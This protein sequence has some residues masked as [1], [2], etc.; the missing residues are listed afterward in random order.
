MRT[1]PSNHERKNGEVPSAAYADGS[2]PQCMT[3]VHFTT[4]PFRHVMLSAAQNLTLRPF[5]ALRVTTLVCQSR[6][7]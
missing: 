5:A 1:A 6:V 4:L 7:V 2:K 3:F